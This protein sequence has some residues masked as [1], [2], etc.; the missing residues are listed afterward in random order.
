MLSH[1]EAKEEPTCKTCRF[2]YYLERYREDPYD[3]G[4]CRRYPPSSDQTEQGF[5]YVHSDWWCGE[6]QRDQ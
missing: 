4:M 1:A 5:V 2:W 3:C 6:Y